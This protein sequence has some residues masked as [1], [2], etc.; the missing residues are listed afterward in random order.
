MS[1]VLLRERG[2]V[3]SKKLS[4]RVSDIEAEGHLNDSRTANAIWEAL[5]FSSLGKLW[6]QEIYFSVPIS[7]ALEDGQEVVQ[8]GCL[9]YWPPGRAFCICFGP[10]PASHGGEIRPASPVTILGNVV[11]ST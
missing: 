8:S 3:M 4:V 7:G 11:G 2:Y 9:A 6:G 10:T 5:P 1:N